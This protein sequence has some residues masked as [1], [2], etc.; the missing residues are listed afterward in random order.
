MSRRGRQ[1]STTGGQHSFARVPSAN[2]Q[3][4]SFN[5][6]HGH[7][8]TFDAGYL[9]P[10]FVDE[11][12]PG[13][14][15]NLR[16]SA[17]ARFATPLHPVMDNLYV[18]VHFFSVPCRLVWDNWQ[19]F[20]GEQDNPGDSVD[21]E[22]PIVEEIGNFAEGS[23]FDYCG[24]PPLVGVIGPNA[25]PFRA[26]N[27]VYNEWFRDENLIDSLPVPKDDGPD[28]KSNYNLFKRNKR[29]DY[30]TS[31]LPWPQKGPSV[32]LPLGDQ[33]PLV[34][35]PDVFAS[36][37][38][39]PTWD[40][41]TNTAFNYQTSAAGT[42]GIEMSENADA[43]DT[44]IKWNNPKLEANLATGGSYADLSQ[45]T[46]ATINQIR[47]AFQIQKLY[48]RDARGG[49][50]YTEQLRSH[51]GVVSPDARLQ[52]PEFLGG[53]TFPVNINPVPQ[54]SSTDVDTTPQGNLAAFGTASTSGTGFVH[55][56]VEHCYVIGF[57][58]ARADLT[59]QEGLHKMWRRKSK[60]DFYWP[61]L[62]HLGEQ[63]VLNEEIYITSDPVENNVVFGY[64]ERFAE[65][66]YKPSLITGKMRSTS[67][68]PLDTWHLSQQFSGYPTLS[69]IF[70]EE[71]PP[72]ARVIAVP[73]EPHFL[74]DTFFQ[75]KCVRPMPTYSVPG[76]VDHF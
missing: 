3:R 47:Q 41:F 2:I 33:A 13:D 70:I 57:I 5:R 22:V 72:I 30:F 71:D 7:K 54:T 8:T 1:P 11:A 60:H 58:S 21:F 15:F 50:R 25:L 34:G 74:L 59:Y 37:D 12:L 16:M 44:E 31:C 64:Q 53:G 35:N 32:F 38:G 68:T 73:S 65:Y 9:I 26:M 24:I 51:F 48:E 39:I 23:I 28:P 42:P 66:R 10:I 69:Q 17:F 46:A 29:H 19:K 36:G 61:T 75:Y 56:F 55:S 67:A 14:T 40:S 27:L 52:R 4:S 20:M 6:S 43:T 63:S 45:A 49:T 76:L 62:A 18:D